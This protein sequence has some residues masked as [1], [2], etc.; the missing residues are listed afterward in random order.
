MATEARRHRTK[1]LLIATV[2]G[3]V[4]VVS[5]WLVVSHWKHSGREGQ[6][7]T[8]VQQLPSGSITDAQASTPQSTTDAGA[9][10]QS[11][12]PAPVAAQ[13]I[14]TEDANLPPT[15]Q[16]APAQPR[17]VESTTDT[18]PQSQQDSPSGSDRYPGS[19]PV[20]VENVN[21]PD[22]GVPVDTE[23]YTTSDSLSAVISYYRQRYPDAE[24]R[25]VNGQ[26][27]IAVSRPGETKVIAL[28]TTGSETRIAIVRAK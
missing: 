18:K 19:Q 5:A 17:P 14:K 7:S 11:H 9:S 1:M 28:G 23:V 3:L 21:L 4:F 27:V 24:L 20:T 25:E 12:P 26:T 16:Q 6:T 10:S 22:I 2:L 15:Q 13:P 8:P